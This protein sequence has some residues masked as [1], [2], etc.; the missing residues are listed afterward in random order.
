MAISR[1]RKTKAHHHHRNL[2]LSRRKLNLLI[3]LD[4]KIPSQLGVPE[5]TNLVVSASSIVS[6]SRHVQSVASSSASKLC[7]QRRTL[8]GCSP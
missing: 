1:S 8:S 5:S 3:L 7:C 4:M 6:R 2:I